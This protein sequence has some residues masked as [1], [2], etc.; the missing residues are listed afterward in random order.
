MPNRS[1]VTAAT[2]I[3]NARTRQSRSS[4]RTTVSARDDSCRTISVPAQ[5]AIAR[6]A[7]EPTVASTRLSASERQRQNG[8]AGHDGRRF[9]RAE[10]ET[11]LVHV[12]SCAAS[13]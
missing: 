8:D 12:A 3:V 2:A 11:K 7:I 5:R 6:P 10:R 1:T 4:G 13:F 9:Q